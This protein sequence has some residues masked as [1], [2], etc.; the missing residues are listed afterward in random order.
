VQWLIKAIHKLRDIPRIDLVHGEKDDRIELMKRTK[1]SSMH[2]HTPR[3][4][5]PYGTHH[6]KMVLTLPPWKSIE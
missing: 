5:L 6:S 1:L 4:P 3:L 2:I